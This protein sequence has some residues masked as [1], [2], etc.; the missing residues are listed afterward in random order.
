MGGFNAAC[1][2]TCTEW[3]RDGALAG[4]SRPRIFRLRVYA[5]LALEAAPRIEDRSKD[6]ESRWIDGCGA[7]RVSPPRALVVV[8]TIDD[9]GKIGRCCYPRSASIAEV[10]ASRQMQLVVSYRP[11][12]TKIILR[13]VNPAAKVLRDLRPLDYFDLACPLRNPPTSETSSTRLRKGAGDRRV[14]FRVV[15]RSFD[16]SLSGLEAPSSGPGLRPSRGRLLASCFGGR[17]TPDT[18]PKTLPKLSRK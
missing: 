7:S 5:P 2:Q 14:T 10:C 18:S 12:F 8:V 16:D 6:G 17:G 9:D 1:F 15:L 11:R 3:Q 13:V 4:S